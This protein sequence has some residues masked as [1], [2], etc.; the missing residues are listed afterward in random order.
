M[1]TGPE[2]L[3]LNAGLVIYRLVSKLAPFPGMQHL[4]VAGGTGTCC[5]GAISGHLDTLS[6]FSI[7][8]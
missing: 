4:D 2:L 8:F 5:A 3:E 1:L 7:G 6:P